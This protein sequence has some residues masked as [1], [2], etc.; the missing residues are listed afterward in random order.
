MAV[1]ISLFLVIGVSL[2]GL[3]FMAWM[4]PSVDRVVTRVAL[5]AFRDAVET[6]GRYRERRERNLHSIHA[7]VTYPV[8]ASKTLLY[9]AVAGIGGSLIAVYGLWLLFQVVTALSERLTRMLPPTMEFL[10]PGAGGFSN[11]SIG[12]I[13][14]L[15][16]LSSATVGTFAA[17]VTYYGRWWYVRNR[18]RRRRV[19][20][21]ES[22]ARTIAFVYALSRSGMVYPEIMRIVGNNRRS[23]GESAEEVGVIVKDMDLFGADIVT[24]FE[25][26]SQRTPSEQFSDFAENFASVLRTGSN[27]SEYLREQYDQYQE[28]RI[29]NQERLLEMFTALGEGYVAGL[30]AG[31]LFLLTI[32][33]IV[34]ILGIESRALL[35]LRGMA[36]VLLPVANIGFI[37]Y[38]DTISESLTS[39]SVPAAQDISSRSISPRRA[40]E[41][42]GAPG[43]TDGGIPERTG[44]GRSERADGGFRID[45]ERRMNQ[46]R[47]R[48]YNRA[49]WLFET[50]LSPVETLVR[51]PVTMLYVTV[52][53]TAVVAFVLAWP[54]VTNGPVD[55]PA[56]DDILIQSTLFVVATFAVARELHTRRLRDIESAIP[57]L[58]DRLASTNEAGMTFTEALRRT[59]RSDLGALNEEVSKLLADIEW[60]AR[61]ERALQRFSTR[62]QSSTISRVVA[63]VTNAMNASGNIGPVIRIAA[64]ESREDSRLRK[65]R[66]QEM[67]MYI[68]II[69]LSFF[70]FI[71]I[72]I[73]LQQVLIP[74]M[75]APDQLTGVGAGVVPEDA[76][77]AEGAPGGVGSAAGAAASGFDLPI[78]PISDEKR[79][80][81]TTVMYHAMM[82]QAIVSG[83]VAGKMGE[84]SVMDGAKHVTVMLAIAYG[85]FVFFGA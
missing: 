57:D 47:L 84:G 52:P 70:V 28:E 38:L 31:P 30:V 53:V 55:V 4:V 78:D 59:D 35:V 63:L 62:L 16:F 85:A 45:P 81:Y 39:Y 32:L 68:I 77:G 21:D 71:G 18:A 74:A 44:G 2:Y 22:I 54:H 79:A 73:A 50:V 61:T 6:A 65:Q 24:A 66:R 1:V 76:G 19:L 15:L 20:I 7:T 17:G 3:L 75:P 10:L 36:Y 46:I 13:F 5:A 34:G 37:L 42:S 69:Y 80:E 72:A 33:L 56:V 60:G 8:Y 58:L 43:A 25:R 41:A 12:Q 23:F 67:F 48:A 11:L 9:S 26:I 64:N 83:F 40:S 82:V 29:A 14:A 49:E 27:V 51:R